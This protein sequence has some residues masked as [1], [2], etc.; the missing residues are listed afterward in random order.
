MSPLMAELLICRTIAVRRANRA[1]RGSLGAFSAAAGGSIA[2]APIAAP[3][4]PAAA[5]RNNARRSRV[6]GFVVFVIVSPSLRGQLHDDAQLYRD[7]RDQR[8]AAVGIPP[9]VAHLGLHGLG[10]ERPAHRV[11]D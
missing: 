3:A 9:A 7:R 8:L 2:V 4:A 5:R 6:P 1:G 11:G 10:I